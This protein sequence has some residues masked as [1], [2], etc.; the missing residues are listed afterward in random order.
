[1]N[2]QSKA[3]INFYTNWIARLTLVVFIF[4][5]TTIDRRLQNLENRMRDL[6]LQITAIS[7]RLGVEPVDSMLGG[8]QSSPGPR[9]LGKLESTGDLHTLEPKNGP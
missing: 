3:R 8:S 4:L 6:E 9:V 7:N 2:D 5:W 1:M